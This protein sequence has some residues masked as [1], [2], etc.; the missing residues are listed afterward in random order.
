MSDTVTIV[1]I[2]GGAGVAVALVT[3]VG[4]YLRE[5]R[6]EGKS[7]AKEHAAHDAADAAIRLHV[8]TELGKLRLV[9][10]ESREAAAKERAECDRRIG[11]L[12]HTVD[13]FVATTEQRIEEHD[14]RIRGIEEAPAAVVAALEKQASVVGE[15]VRALHDSRSGEMHAVRPP[16]VGP[17]VYPAR[18]PRD[19]E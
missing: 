14:R 9:Q 6:S 13:R 10:A 1:G 18:R 15:L 2:L 16:P 17:G 19:G 7:E 3:Q 11:D 8:E 5:T 4:R 12:A